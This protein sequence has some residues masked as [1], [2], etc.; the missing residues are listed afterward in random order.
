MA[1]LVVFTLSWC[2]WVWSHRFISLRNASIKQPSLTFLHP[3]CGW[4]RQSV[5]WLRQPGTSQNSNPWLGLFILFVF[6]WVVLR[7]LSVSTLGLLVKCRDSCDT[8]FPP[9]KRTHTSAK[10]THKNLK[11][12]LK[13]QSYSPSKVFALSGTGAMLLTFCSLPGTELALWCRPVPHDCLTITPTKHAAV[14]FA[15]LI[16]IFLDPGRIFLLLRLFSL[17]CS[18]GD[19]IAGD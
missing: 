2:R 13:T 8:S 12:V 3:E 6:I 4:A 16:K 7:L 9:A 15:I 1:S 18:L 11:S 5:R 14:L 17:S 19:V 10:A